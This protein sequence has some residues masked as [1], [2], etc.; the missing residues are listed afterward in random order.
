MRGICP[1]R[2]NLSQTRLT[3]LAA[4]L[5]VTTVSVIAFSLLT[6]HPIYNTPV[7]LT[8]TYNKPY[9]GKLWSV[10]NFTSSSK[11]S[12]AWFSFGFAHNN[13]S[14]GPLYTTVSFAGTFNVVVVDSV[15]M[16]FST[17]QSGYTVDVGARAPFSTSVVHVD[18]TRTALDEIVEYPSLASQ[19][20]GTQTSLLWFYLGGMS[21]QSG[22]HTV[23][24]TVDLAA[25]DAQTSLTGHSYSAEAVFHIIVQPN[26]L[27]YVSDQ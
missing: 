25:H 15:M 13:E 20:Q 5:A 27:V 17:D 12:M 19:P 8:T 1:V 21:A 11:A 16:T 14:V 22:N 9:E 23:T 3:V 18:L 4:A 24:M 7:S 26:G 10:A 2:F 6:A